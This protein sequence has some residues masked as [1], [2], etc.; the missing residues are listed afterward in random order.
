M[1]GA[2]QLADRIS[3]HSNSEISWI[4]VLGL[5]GLPK[6][7]SD[8]K[9]V[10]PTVVA[11][12]V[13]QTKVE[14]V[15]QLPPP[16]PITSEKARVVESK[17]VEAKG[18]SREDEDIPKS[19]SDRDSKPSPKLVPDNITTPAVVASAAAPKQATPAISP[20]VAS[21]PAVNP[22][23]PVRSETPPHVNTPVRAPTINATRSQS[24]NPIGPS[25]PRAANSSSNTDPLTA[26]RS[27]FAS[28]D[29]NGDGIVSHIELIKALRANPQLAKVLLLF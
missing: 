23:S 29:R 8:T 12:P 15:V 27:I 7:E 6:K 13:K 3:R 25:P 2:S 11:E 19:S 14:T 4:E 24:P 20:V 9:K 17:A 10:E 26:A 22:P 16:N 18:R 28:I 5:A 1:L 21:S